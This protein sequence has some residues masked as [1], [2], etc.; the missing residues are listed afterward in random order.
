MGVGEQAARAC[1]CNA[2]RAR[3][4]SLASLAFLLASHTSLHPY[5]RT[6]MAAKGSNTTPVVVSPALASA[7]QATRA[8]ASCGAVGHAV[9][10]RR[11]ASD[12]GEPRC[13]P[14]QALGWVQGAEGVRAACRRR[15]RGA[16]HGCAGQHCTG[17]RAMH[18]RH[19]PR[20]TCLL[21]QGALAGTRYTATLRLHGLSPSH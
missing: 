2:C 6:L 7:R 17:L 19:K 9:L 8:R 15:G 14:Q 21:L 11:A 1:R 18:F 16:C 3:V 12:P 13:H 5:K 4:A 10:Q 20:S